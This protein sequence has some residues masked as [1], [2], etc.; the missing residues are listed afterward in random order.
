M[1]FGVKVRELMKKKGI[2]QNE[3][4]KM[5]GLSSS[6]ISTALNSEGNPRSTTMAAIAEA[7]GCT[8]AE[9]IGEE[10]AQPSPQVALPHRLMEM[11]A[12]LNEE[13]QQRLME[14]AEDMT[15]L[16]RWTQKK[17]TKAV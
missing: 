8:V 4:A 9:L 11:Y 5:A 16:D 14:L 7:L 1:S 10:P 12:A 2:T 15:Q 17:G 3:L 6:G 13:G